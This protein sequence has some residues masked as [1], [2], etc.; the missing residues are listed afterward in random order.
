MLLHYEA[1]EGHLGVNRTIAK[2]DENFFW[3]GMQKIVSNYIRSCLTSEKFKPSKENAKTN[4]QPI[5]I[6]H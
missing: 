4:L 1:T 6:H 3:P 5:S 2:F